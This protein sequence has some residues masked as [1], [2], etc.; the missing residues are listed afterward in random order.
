MAADGS[1][2]EDDFV[3]GEI[4]LLDDVANDALGVSLYALLAG[5]L[6]GV[7]TIASVLHGD[8]VESQLS[9]DVLAELLNVK[10][11]L[12]VGMEVEHD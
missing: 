10:D 11:V 7:Q 6:V 5:G 1:P 3:A 4:Q 8:H 12:C 9:A 2:A